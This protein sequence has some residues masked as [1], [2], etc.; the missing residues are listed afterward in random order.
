[1]FTTKSV[2][3]RGD[4]RVYTEVH[5]GCHWDAAMKKCFG[6]SEECFNKTL[7]FKEH[8]LPIL[9]LIFAKVR[10][11]ASRNTSQQSFSAES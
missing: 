3:V 10:F 4:K 8:T 5:H 2:D 1:V 9:L 6:S 7:F 11:S